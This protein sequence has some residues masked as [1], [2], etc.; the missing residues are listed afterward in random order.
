MMDYT[1]IGGN[2]FEKKV[3]LILKNSQVV[4][5]KET[6]ELLENLSKD[7][8]KILND[9][10]LY[11]GDDNIF[12]TIGK[13]KIQKEFKNIQDFSEKWYKNKTVDKINQ[14]R[15]LLEKEIESLFLNEE[16]NV[17]EDFSGNSLNLV[18]FESEF[19]SE[20]QKKEIENI[21]VTDIEHIKIHNNYQLDL[22]AL[23]FPLFSLKLDRKNL[24]YHFKTRDNVEITLD[25]NRRGRATVQDADLWLYCIT[26]MAQLIYEKGIVTRRVTFT[27]ADFLKSTGR[28]GGSNYQQIILSLQRLKGTSL[29]TN[30][31]IGTFKVGGGNGLIDSYKYVEDLGKKKIGFEVVL[32]EWLF[33]EILNKKI[34]GINPKYLK[35]K[36]LEKRLYQLAKYHCRDNKISSTF[37]L[38]YFSQK[39]GIKNNLRDF[40][41]QIKKLIL[42]QEERQKEIKEW[43][44]SHPNPT[45]EELQE[46][47]FLPLIEYLI[48]YE[49]ESGDKIGKVYFTNQ[50]FDIIPKHSEA[51][52]RIEAKQIRENIE[53]INF[54]GGST[55]HQKENT[56]KIIQWLDLNYPLESR[57][58]YNIFQTKILTENKILEYLRKFEPE[59]VLSN[60]R[61]F[62]EYD[63]KK[64]ENP[65]AYFYRILAK[66][67]VNHRH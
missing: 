10:I 42:L 7:D 33:E 17:S 47:P 2:M 6:L 65:E 63:F 26:K 36:P 14:F 57:R 48:H 3:F 31:Q 28:K 51:K 64:C 15:S 45:K 49:K 9:L 37:C 22:F 23:Q 66:V 60:I 8:L 30:Q 43:E 53:Q 34:V 44:L 50:N 27:G 58:K 5:S 32:P 16:I 12:P 25:C 13:A 59:H 56:Q 38:N 11:Y 1:D 19:L 46:K 67:A 41:Y 54:V 62:I 21:P 39:I 61:A 40:R 35:L 20:V 52:R 55:K 4:I 18:E 29:T 24:T